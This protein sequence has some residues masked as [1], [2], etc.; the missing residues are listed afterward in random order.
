MRALGVGASR[1]RCGKSTGRS[2]S[3]RV[4]II[5]LLLRAAPIICRRLSTS[6][7]A[8]CLALTLTFLGQPAS[9]HVCAFAFRSRRSGAVSHAIFSA[10]FLQAEGRQRFSLTRTLL[11]MRAFV[12]LLRVKS[13]AALINF[14]KFYIFATQTRT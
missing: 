6:P 8:A 1:W 5:G 12:D 11:R 10:I 2:R 7:W 9:E 3:R 4:R 14:D 13:R